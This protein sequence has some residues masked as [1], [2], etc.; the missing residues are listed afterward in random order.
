MDDMRRVRVKWE[1]PVRL[2]SILRLNSDDDY[3]LY[4]IYCHHVVFG[5]GSLVYIGKAIEQTFAARFKQHEVDWLS[6]ENDIT[7][8]VGR[9]FRDDYAKDNDWRD[10]KKL[11]TDTEALLIHWHS[12]PYNSQHISDYRGQGLH[13]Q[14]W[15]NRGS[16]LPECTS[17]WDARRPREE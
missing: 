3:G 9:L 17:A 12:P 15:G 14:N 13:A 7:I 11:L 6:E 2:D 8:R 1:N 10:W 16:I 4:Q 5:P